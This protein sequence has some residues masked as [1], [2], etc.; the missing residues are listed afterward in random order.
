MLLLLVLA[1]AGN[2]GEMYEAEKA[3]ALAAPPT[4]GERWS[5][6]L[7]LRIAEDALGRAAREV[8]AA[9]AL[10]VER[11]YG[12]DNPLNIP[13]KARPSAR[14]TRL[15]VSMG[16][17]CSGCL[18]LDARLE[19]KTRWTAGP[20]EGAVPFR[21]RL[22]GQMRFSTQAQGQGWQVTGRIVEVGRIKVQAGSVRAID[23]A[24]VVRGW[25]TEA[26]EKAPPIQLGHLGGGAMP[27]RAIRIGESEGA[28]EI[29]AL[30]DTAGGRP[31]SAASAPPSTDWDLRMHPDTA[32]ALI[33]R[34]AF[35][36]GP[37]EL[38]VAIDP[39]ALA[40][41]GDR[42]TLALRLWRLKGAGWWR[43]YT[44]DGRLGVQR[45]SL[46]MTG[47]DAQEGEKSR[48][49]GL[50]DPIAL[51]AEGRILDA[52]GDGV[53][54]SLPATQT[55]DLKGVRLAARVDTA[56]GDGSALAVA[57]P[58]RISAAGAGPRKDASHGR[59]N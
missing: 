15:D 44:V 34:M 36:A 47:K 16:E 3:A 28:L 26:L 24:P 40:V 54:Q 50:A 18:L 41:D 8:V 30:G 23:L 7:R 48:G 33:R 25:A 35:E 56:R 14:V 51:L 12:V 11:A 1:C 10:R 42:F 46:R 52:V 38:D 21:I 6:E 55:L 4:P 29:Q 37:Q 9:G 45:G 19:G 39:R 22:A 5:P 32:L 49:A 20:A 43:D 31:V 27:L 57:G 2:I 59:S 58:L 17:D 53:D 13:L